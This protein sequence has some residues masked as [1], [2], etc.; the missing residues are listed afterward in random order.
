MLSA[1][2]SACKSVP[3]TGEVF[4][5]PVSTTRW[6]QYQDQFQ[7]TYTLTEEQA[8]KLAVPTTIQLEQSILDSVAAAAKIKLIG[9]EFPE[10]D[11]ISDVTPSDTSDPQQ[12]ASTP[13]AKEVLD[14]DK[15][16]VDPRLQYLLATA[17]WQE[18][19][20]LNRY[21]SDAAFKHKIQSREF[22]PYV[23]RMQV[24]NLPSSV[25]SS[26]V[27]DI[28]LNFS[29]DQ[30]EQPIVVPLLINDHIEAALASRRN[31]EVRRVALSLAA[32]FKGIGADLSLET[33]NAEL[34]RSL[35]REMNSLLTVTNTSQSSLRIRLGPRRYAENDYRASS[36][37]RFVTVLLLIPSTELTEKDRAG[38][39]YDRGMVADPISATAQYTYKLHDP[40]SGLKTIDPNEAKAQKFVV[41]GRRPR[42]PWLREVQTALAYDDGNTTVVTLNDAV[43]IIPDNVVA[44]WFFKD[45]T[46]ETVHA[47]SSGETKYNGNDKQLVFKFPSLK[48][49]G[50]TPHNTDKIPDRYRR[51]QLSRLVSDVTIEKEDSVEK[52]VYLFYPWIYKSK[53]APTLK[54]A[55]KLVVNR[56]K[57]V[58]DKGTD[59]IKVH[60]I[61]PTDKDKNPIKGFKLMV[62]GADATI[63]SVVPKG[64]A[65]PPA[66]DT[67]RIQEAST[68]NSKASIIMA[69]GREYSSYQR[70]VINR[71]YDNQDTILATRLGEIVTDIALAQDDQKKLDRLWKRAEQA[72]SKTNLKPES[73]KNIVQ[74]RDPKQLAQLLAKL[75]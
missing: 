54:P 31:E 53:D 13:S 14:T 45:G 59:T 17:L 69:G 68:S 44:T 65:A 11:Q 28:D 35:S 41:E 61:L 29:S 19:Q 5:S 52:N 64:G 20:I 43:N 8:L 48:R 15:L 50:I 57:V 16:D 55:A 3:N 67:D 37:P 38:L 73:W 39:N 63:L 47:I 9:G 34:N 6:D 27:A 72:L 56:T 23:V 32:M 18:I 12:P 21:V 33:L 49:M 2:L 1:V 58:P 7:P 62:E 25:K 42:Y 75:A 46:S 66:K 30:D 26:Y 36:E 71:Y 70:K 74:N 22:V 40:I 4:I 10:A 51:Y 24:S 60:I